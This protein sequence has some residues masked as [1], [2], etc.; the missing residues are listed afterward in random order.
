MTFSPFLFFFFHFSFSLTLSLIAHSQHPN[1]QTIPT[2]NQITFVASKQR[3]RRLFILCHSRRSRR[4]NDPIRDDLAV[5]TIVCRSPF[6]TISPSQPSF[7]DPHSRRSRRCDH[8][9]PIPI[10][11]DLAELFSIAIT[12]ACN[13]R[14]YRRRIYSPSSLKLAVIAD[15][16]PATFRLPPTPTL[17]LP[18]AGSA[19]TA[20]RLPPTPTVRLPFAA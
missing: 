3:S 2:P 20:L 9:L 4:C 8:R 14:F 18:F 16:T 1:I 5:A 12:F 11:N 13:R 6:A 15:Q 17:Q 7:A 19:P 10:C